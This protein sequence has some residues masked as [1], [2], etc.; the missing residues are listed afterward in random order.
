MW[1][2]DP[3]ADILVPR[4]CFLRPLA[5]GD[6]GSGTLVARDR[7][8]F[9][10]VTGPETR[11]VAVR[12]R[13]VSRLPVLPPPGMV[14]ASFLQLSL[15]LVLLFALILRPSAPQILL[16]LALP[17]LALPQSEQPVV[18]PARN[19]L[20]ARRRYRLCLQLCDLRLCKRRLPADPLLA[21]LSALACDSADP[22]LP[23]V[24]GTLG[25]LAC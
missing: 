7:L 22:G 14:S 23:L 16:V 21:C 6:C 1:C 17:Q 10:V 9:P 13:V 2:A 5:R 11:A 20:L 3:R 24:L 12:R 25:G 4:D 19:V 18:S 15:T 8:Y